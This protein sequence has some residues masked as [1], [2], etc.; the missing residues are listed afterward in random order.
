MYFSRGWIDGGEGL[1]EG[2]GYPNWGITHS[3]IGGATHDLASD[4]PRGT[5]RVSF[6][7]DC[8]HWFHEAMYWGI[9]ALGIVAFTNVSAQLGSGTALL[10]RVCSAAATLMYRLYRVFLSRLLRIM[11]TRVLLWQGR[12]ADIDLMSPSSLWLFTPRTMHTSAKIKA[13][14]LNLKKKTNK[15]DNKV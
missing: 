7:S 1:R 8:K 2:Y 11:E 6:G 5:T 15:H 12:H 4:N 13:G 10:K 9:F 3:S 14:V